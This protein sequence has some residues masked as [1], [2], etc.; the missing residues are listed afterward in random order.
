MSKLIFAHATRNMVALFCF[1]TIFSY[2]TSA[3]ADEGGCDSNGITGAAQVANTILEHAADQVNQKALPTLQQYVPKAPAF[4]LGRP[5]YLFS[6]GFEHRFGSHLTL[7]PYLGFSTSPSK[8]IYTYTGDGNYDGMSLG[9][10]QVGMNDR[11]YMGVAGINAF[12]Q[13]GRCHAWARWVIG[14]GFALTGY[15]GG[16]NAVGVPLLFGDA[17]S[18]SYQGTYW[19]FGGYAEALSG[20]RFDFLR[21]GSLSLL[22]GYRAGLG[23]VHIN[24]TVWNGDSALPIYGPEIRAVLAL[25]F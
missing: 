7:D 12:Y 6:L 19:G 25:G 14:G 20:V 2:A 5:E 21:H 18:Q 13:T 1:L 4:N 3:Q 17:F 8:Q 22:G 15:Q 9:P 10:V 24:S 16:L 23:Y 11:G